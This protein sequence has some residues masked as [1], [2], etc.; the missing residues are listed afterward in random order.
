MVLMNYSSN[1]SLKTV[2][3]RLDIHKNYN[4]TIRRNE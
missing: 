1:N 2:G 3:L 4:E